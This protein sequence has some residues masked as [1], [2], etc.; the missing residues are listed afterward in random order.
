MTCFVSMMAEERREE[1]REDGAGRSPAKDCVR[2]E[3]ETA[4]KN[5]FFNV[6]GTKMLKECH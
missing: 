1:R 4:L 6:Y 5:P 2:H 3:H